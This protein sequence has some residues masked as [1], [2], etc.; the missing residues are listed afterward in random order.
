MSHNL[1]NLIQL[2]NYTDVTNHFSV[3]DLKDKITLKN[4]LQSTLSRKYNMEKAHL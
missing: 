2:I 3:E 4:S 1:I